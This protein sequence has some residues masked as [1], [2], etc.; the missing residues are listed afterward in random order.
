MR[1]RGGRGRPGGREGGMGGG[2][3]APT[4]VICWFNWIFFNGRPRVFHYAKSHPDLLFIGVHLRAEFG[5]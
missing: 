3:E 4:L 1:E 2:M 5:N